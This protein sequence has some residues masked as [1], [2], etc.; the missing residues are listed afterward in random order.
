[1]KALSVSQE[2]ALRHLIDKPFDLGDR[3]H[4]FHMTKPTKTLQSLVRHGL[5]SYEIGGGCSGTGQYSLTDAG[6]TAAES[7]FRTGRQA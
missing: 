7:L 2:C 3:E 1:M 6:Q 5:I 4:L